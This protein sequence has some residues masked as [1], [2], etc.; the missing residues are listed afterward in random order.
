MSSAS[1]MPPTWYPDLQ[2]EQDYLDLLHH[3]LDNLREE[4]ER[5]LRTVLRES[6]GTAQRQLER[7]APAGRLSRQLATLD[8][9]EN[10]LCFGRLD[11][12]DG[13]RFYIGRI[14]L[15]GSEPD[16]DPLL[17]DW[18]APAARPFYTATAAAPQGVRLRRHLHTRNRRVVRTDDELFGDASAVSDDIQ[19]SSEAAALSS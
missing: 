15:P 12:V 9:D 8:A 13:D 17:I 16:E 2:R 1:P 10:G 3:R 6:T 14:G 19:L 7:G 18:R 4:I 5:E 11:R